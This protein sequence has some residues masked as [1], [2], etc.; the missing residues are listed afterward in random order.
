MELVELAQVGLAGEH[1]RACSNLAVRRPKRRP[2]ARQCTRFD[3]GHGGSF[4]DRAAQSLDGPGQAANELARMDHGVLAAVDRAERTVDPDPFGRLGGI[5]P[6]I[7]LGPAGLLEAVPMRIECRHLLPATSDRERAA[8]GVVG[9]DP[10]ERDRRAHFVDRPGD[11]LLDR[12]HALPAEPS[13]EAIRAGVQPGC[14]PA[15]VPPGGAEAGDLPFDEHD[16]QRGIAAEQGRR[17][18]TTRYSPPP[19][20]PRRH[21]SRRAA[22]AGGQVV[23]GRLQPVARPGIAGRVNELARPRSTGRWI[24]TAYAQRGSE[25]ANGSNASVRSTT[26]SAPSRAWLGRSRGEPRIE[27]SRRSPALPACVI[28]AATVARA[29]SRA[30]PRGSIGP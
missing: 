20:S 23:A 25:V 8:L 30:T 17:P 27:P 21:R 11:G 18:S 12:G 15:A 14:H 13:L 26:A 29:W 22:R 9:V 1:D 4:E 2:K 19:G 10:L 16:L 5:E 28:A 24:G 6:A 7:A 3:V